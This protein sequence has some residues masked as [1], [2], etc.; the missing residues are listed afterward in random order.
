MDV[1]AKYLSSPEVRR[2]VLHLV[3]PQLWQARAPLQL[4]HP[5]LAVALQGRQQALV[6]GK[7]CWHQQNLVLE[8]QFLDWEYKIVLMALVQLLLE[9]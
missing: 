7:L 8:H 6:Q 1:T 4:G 9:L 2:K 3:C 5:L